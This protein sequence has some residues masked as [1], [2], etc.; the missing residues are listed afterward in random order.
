MSLKAKSCGVTTQMEPFAS[1]FT[2]WFFVFEHFTK[3][4][5]KILPKFLLR[6]NLGVKVLI[7]SNY[8]LTL[9]TT[10]TLYFTS[11]ANVF[12]KKLLIDFFCICW[13]R[14]HHLTGSSKPREGLEPFASR[15]HAFY[16]FY[17]KNLKIAPVP[18]IEPA[19]SHSAAQPSLTD[20]ATGSN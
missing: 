4:N 7:T 19:T 20:W 11:G 15:G 17:F 9:P 16:T 2:R 1:T 3:W 5:L 14:D 13:R 12:S 18:G 6:S 10:A 8:C